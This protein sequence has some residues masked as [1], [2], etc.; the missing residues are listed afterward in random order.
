LSGL[1]AAADAVIGKDIM[2]VGLPYRLR[3]AFRKETSP[4]KN[5]VAIGTKGM[6]GANAVERKVAEKAIQIRIV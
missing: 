3:A 5:F 4:D 1:G 2:P 6:A